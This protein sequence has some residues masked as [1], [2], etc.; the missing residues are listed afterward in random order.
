[1]RGLRLGY[2][3]AGYTAAAAVMA[4]AMQ[5][6][7]VDAIVALDSLPEFFHLACQ[8][9]LPPTLLL[10]GISEATVEH[11]AIVGPCRPNVVGGNHSSEEIAALSASWFAEHLARAAYRTSV[12]SYTFAAQAAVDARAA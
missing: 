1:M 4:A 11:A 5:P 10:G 2:F 8:R 3:G 7:A 9:A 6:G 12:M